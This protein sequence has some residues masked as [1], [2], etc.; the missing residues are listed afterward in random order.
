MINHLAIILDGNRR[1]AK[2]NGLPAAQG[3]Y[4]GYENVKTIGLAAFKRE[5]KYFTVFAFSTENWKRSKMEV[6]YLMS[7]IHQTLTTDLDFFMTHDVRLKVI[8]RREGL[9]K[10]I[11]TAIDAAEQASKDNKK[12]QLTICLNYGGRAEIVDATKRLIAKGYKEHQI[13]EELLDQHMWTAGIPDP[14]LC[15]RTSGEQRLSNFLTWQSVYSEW[16][17]IKKGWPDFTV[18][19]L[20]AA[21]ASYEQRERRHGA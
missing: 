6:T 10:K 16:L 7:L 8:G 5:V 18:D 15:I 3:H 20:E 13:T 11:L 1:W 14:D 21:I 17:F 4:R 2:A 19:D 9:S 12:G